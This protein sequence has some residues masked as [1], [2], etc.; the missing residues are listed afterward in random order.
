MPNFWA[1]G[2]KLGQKRFRHFGYFQPIY[3][4]TVWYCDSLVHVFHYTAKQNPVSQFSQV[5]NIFHYTAKQNPVSQFSL[6]PVKN[7][8][9]S[10]RVS[11]VL[12]TL[13][14]DDSTGGALYEKTTFSSEIFNVLSTDCHSLFLFNF[15]SSKSES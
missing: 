12:A 9:F 1:L 7:W 8:G 6:G 10:Y 5:K 13:P 3:H 15:S 2:D 14:P 11:V 4:H